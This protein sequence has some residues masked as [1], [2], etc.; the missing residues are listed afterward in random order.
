MNT[1][2]NRV[3]L[4]LCLGLA[5]GFF[6]CAGTQQTR[7]TASTLVP[8]AEGYV[9]TEEGKNG[10]ISLKILVK[11][12]AHPEKLQTGATIYVAWLQPIDQAVPQNMG[13]LNVGKNLTG[14]LQTSTPHHEFQLWIT[15]EAFPRA[16][17]PS[18]PEVFRTVVRDRQ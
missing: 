1:I 15:A 7:M 9:Q 14:L 18:G 5:G 16:A 13:A 10:N 6:A 11:H 12:L 3:A 2:K 8:A 17:A 4:T